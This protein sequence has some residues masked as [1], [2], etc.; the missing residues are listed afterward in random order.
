MS[1]WHLQACDFGGYYVIYVNI[2]KMEVI[3]VIFLKSGV[4]FL[5]FSV[6]RNATPMSVAAKTTEQLVR[7]RAKRISNYAKFMQE[8]LQEANEKMHC[9]GRLPQYNTIIVLAARL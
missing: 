8:T 4:N 1:S 9:D 3:Y 7:H 6:K 2:L 5:C